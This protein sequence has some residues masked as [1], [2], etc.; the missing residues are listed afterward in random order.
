MY[1]YLISSNA[2]H[3]ICLFL[4]Q[5]R[6]ISS[7]SAVSNVSTVN[8]I[9]TWVLTY[10]DNWLLQTL[11]PHKPWIAW[12]VLHVMSIVTGIIGNLCN[13][14]PKRLVEPNCSYSDYF[15][16]IS[17]STSNSRAPGGPVTVTLILATC[18]SQYF[19]DTFSNPHTQSS[20]LVIDKSWRFW[21]L[22]TTS[23]GNKLVLATSWI[24]VDTNVHLTWYF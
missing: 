1:H 7:E 3:S 17:G 22:C 4:A 10:Y 16:A 21:H 12:D 23:N 19:S 14:C 18:L 9:F 6:L 13:K 15:N 8:T 20:F 11:C 24:N 5:W 2:S